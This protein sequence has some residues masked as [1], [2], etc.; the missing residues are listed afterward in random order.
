MSPLRIIAGIVAAIVLSVQALSAQYD[1]SAEAKGRSGS[2]LAS[3]YLD[4]G[5]PTSTFSDNMRET[6]V[7]VGGEML[8][9]LQKGG[10]VWAGI[11]VHSFAFDDFSITYF[12]QIDFDYIEIKE[13]T[14]SRL[15]VAA[16]VMRF[17]PP[18]DFVLRPY[19]QG[20]FGMHWFFTN[21]KIEDVEFDEVVSTIKE[22]SDSELGFSLHAGVMVVT[23]KFPH[24]RGDVRFGF[25]RNASVEYMRYN[26]NLPSPSGFPIDY[27]EVKESPVEMLGVHVGVT[28]VM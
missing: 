5:I 15:F 22:N 9:N 21:T 8:I 12:D 18:V 17:Q 28:L 24:I 11:G 1:D 4:V 26:A 14:A 3:L 2:F 10:P 20:A 19:F 16:A 13:L 27:F 6:G 23:R 7:G 25:F